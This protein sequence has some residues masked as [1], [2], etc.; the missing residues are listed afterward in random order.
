M[1]KD[2]FCLS[3]LRQ[4]FN[5][6]MACHPAIM[7]TRQPA[8]RNIGLVILKHVVLIRGEDPGPG[9]LQVDLKD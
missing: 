8:R 1:S 7:I 6:I 5:H 4:R 2:Q 9:V 3:S